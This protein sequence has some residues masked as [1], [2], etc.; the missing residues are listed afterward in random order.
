MET[1]MDKNIHKNHRKRLRD[2]FERE[3]ADSFEVHEIL[4]LF[5]FDAIPRVS[6]NAIAHRLLDRF[7]D[8][9]GVF[10]A[11]EKELM[12]VKGIGSHA[13][14]YIV[15][16]SKEYRA[17]IEE[18]LLK[19]PLSS[20]SRAANYFIHKL[21]DDEFATDADRS[22]VIVMLDKDF[23]VTDVRCYHHG[24]VL[25]IVEDCA[26]AGAVKALIGCGKE[27]CDEIVRNADIF[28]R[29]GTELCDVIKVDGFDAE[30]MIQQ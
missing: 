29:F 23:R 27:I 1:K 2:R 6:T 10:S 19:R 21:R 20:F 9:N 4:E 7:G 25:L 16:A 14:E 5:L 15:N 12:T 28:R 18:E 26:T 30:S 13:A 8:L 17:Q 11:T 24:R 3:G 22:A